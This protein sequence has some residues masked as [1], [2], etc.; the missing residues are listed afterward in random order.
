MYGCFFTN[1]TY[2]FQNI[3]RTSLR[4]VFRWYVSWTLCGI[5]FVAPQPLIQWSGLYS[6]RNC[7]IINTRRSHLHIWSLVT[8]VTG[9][10]FPIYGCICLKFMIIWH[11]P[12]V[13][14]TLLSA[15][16][17]FSNPSETYLPYSSNAFMLRRLFNSAILMHEGSLRF[18][19]EELIE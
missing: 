8:W 2:A 14:F 19:F 4:C 1:N 18:F 13:I 6:L 15:F 11:P 9:V 12:E 10:S 5:V 17:P 7:N 3:Q 16:T